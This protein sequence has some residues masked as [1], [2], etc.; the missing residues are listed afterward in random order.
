MGYLLQNDGHDAIMDFFGV[1]KDCTAHWTMPYPCRRL[2]CS[3]FNVDVVVA[4][5]D[6]IMVYGLPF[7]SF[8]GSAVLQSHRQRLLGC[9]TMHEA[10][11]IILLTSQVRDLVTWRS[12]QS[13]L[14]SSS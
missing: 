12:A 11:A 6:A 5:Y 7:A 13:V 14:R 1:E 10:F 3:T 9:S 2:F 8:V 4:I